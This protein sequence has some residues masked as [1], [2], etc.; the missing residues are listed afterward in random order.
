MT[1]LTQETKVC[2]IRCISIYSRK[3]KNISN[4]RGEIYMHVSLILVSVCQF[5]LLICTI[6]I[7][8]NIL[9][10]LRTHVHNIGDLRMKRVKW[11][12]TTL[13]N[14]FRTEFGLRRVFPVRAGIIVSK[15]RRFM[16]NIFV[17]LFQ[18]KE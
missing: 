10:H 17:F 12:G 6:L 13:S 11:N 3:Y 15:S 9:V 4:N 1:D 2:S 16:V 8:L 5:N 7:L 18:Q 14:S